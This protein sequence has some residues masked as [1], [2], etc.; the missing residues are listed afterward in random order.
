IAAASGLTKAARIMLE[1]AKPPKPPVAAQV[2]PS[3]V[4]CLIIGA[5]ATGLSA[6]HH[7]GEGS[8]VLEREAKVGGGCRSIEDTGF[9]FDHAG[10]VMFSDDPYVQDLHRL[11]LGDNVH[12]QERN[13]WIY[14]KGVYTRYPFQGALHGLPPHVLRECLVGAIEARFGALS[15]GDETALA[16]GVK[17]CCA[18]ATGLSSSEAVDS[19]ATAP[20]NFEEFIYR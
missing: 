1:P 2:A 16:P 20:R 9:M 10:H 7:Y 14:R 17:D 5:G 11:L 4:A 8:V 18:G 12:W 3:A 19:R 6:A 15:H 13:A